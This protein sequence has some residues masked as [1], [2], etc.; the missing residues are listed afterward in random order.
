M[1]DYKQNIADLIRTLAEDKEGIKKK[2]DAKGSPD[3]DE[4]LES[5]AVKLEPIILFFNGNRL[6]PSENMKNWW[7]LSM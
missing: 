7:I 4:A 6:Q 2:L 5:L 3:K 1:R